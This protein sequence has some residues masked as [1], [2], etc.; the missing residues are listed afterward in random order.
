MVIKRATITKIS[1]EAAKG[2]FRILLALLLEQVEFFR[3]SMILTT[4]FSCCD[5]EVMA[6][7]S[8]RDNIRRDNKLNE[9]IEN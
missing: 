8:I 5:I 7:L 6:V 1:R 9:L 2:L 4:I 3:L